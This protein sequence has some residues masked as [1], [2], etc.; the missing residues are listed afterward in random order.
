MFFNLGL[1]KGVGVRVGVLIDRFKFI[2]KSKNFGWMDIVMR[3][4]W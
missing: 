1:D 4:I 3:Y 2:L